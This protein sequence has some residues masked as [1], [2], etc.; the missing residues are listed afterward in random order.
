M[1]VSH[2][3]VRAREKDEGGSGLPGTQQ[4]LER[5]REEDDGNEAVGV[6]KGAKRTCNRQS[7]CVRP[8]WLTCRFVPEVADEGRCAVG[9]CCGEKNVQ[10]VRG[11]LVHPGSGQSRVGPYWRRSTTAWCGESQTYTTMKT[12]VV[13]AACMHHL[14]VARTSLLTLSGKSN[15]RGNSILSCLNLTSNLF[16][17][18]VRLGS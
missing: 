10:K 11:A 2:G 12:A 6:L 18:P 15:T 9:N 16:L 4:R 7:W 13:I 17:R 8:Q 3:G 5:E 1:S 14:Q